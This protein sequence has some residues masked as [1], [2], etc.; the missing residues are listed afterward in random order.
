MVGNME[1][2]Q[3]GEQWTAWVGG[4][5]TLILRLSHRQ[6]LHRYRTNGYT[7]HQ[8]M[9][10]LMSVIVTF[11]YGYTHVSYSNEWLHSCQLQ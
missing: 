7:L 1:P 5:V 6:M 2:Y 9:V 4:D 11:M 10:T 3:V 8:P